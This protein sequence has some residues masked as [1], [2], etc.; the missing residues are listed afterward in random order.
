M[1]IAMIGLRGIP[2]SEDGGG[3]DRHVDEL[4]TRLA[5]LGHEVIVYVRPRF[6]PEG[7]TMYKGVKLISIGSIPTK[8]LDTITHVLFATINVL[9]RKVDIVHYHGVGPSTLSWI[10]RIFKP[11]V[12][13][14]TT[15]HSIDR[16]HKKW[17]F[18]ARL[19]LSWGEWTACH[20]AHKTLVVGEVLQKYCLDKYKKET[21]FIPNGV[22]IKR[23][24][25][26]DQLKQFG[27]EK[28]Q[29][30]LTVARLVK[31]KGIHLLIEAYKK[32][33]KKYGKNNKKWPRE[34][35]IKLVIVGSPSYTEDYLE[36]LKKIAGKSTN[37]IF[38]G[39]QGGTI[40]DQLFA[41]A[42]LYVHPSQAEGLSTTILESLSHRM[43]A[44]ISDITENL[45]VI[46]HSGFMFKTN[47]VDDLYTKLIDLLN[48]PEKIALKKER[49]LRFIKN[50]FDWDKNI[51]RV[52]KEYM[53]LL[54][55]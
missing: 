32:I 1:K 49:A 11:K 30:L 8:H 27:L 23:I 46:D 7:I 2:F 9:F 40:L 15:F 36:Y 29:Y 21:V 24:N 44:L 43:P 33:E 4:S 22:T 13:V 35:I 48:H 5:K 12:K 55:A 14:V 20:F 18:L 38:T 53:K 54:K 31:H 50:N 45:E 6:T 42:Y 3:V 39:F 25:Q 34:K 16:F 17:G 19:Y 41:N 52:E 28:D 47:D 37:I 26:A 10:V 51:K